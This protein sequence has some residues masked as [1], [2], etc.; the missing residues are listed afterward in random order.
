MNEALISVI[1]PV[2]NTPLKWVD[3]CVTSIIRQDYKNMEILIVDDGNKDIYSSKLKE[4]LPLDDRIRLIYRENG[5]VSSARNTGLDEAKGQYITFVD[6]D[7]Q[8]EAGAIKS[9]IELLI[10]YNA[11]IAVG[12][13]VKFSPY[14]FT[15]SQA[16]KNDLVYLYE[17]EQV[18]GLISFLLS[19]ESKDYRV[20]KMT[21]FGGV[22]CR[23]YTRAVIDRVRFD[24][25]L[26]FAEDS[27]FNIRIFSRATSVIVSSQIWYRYRMTDISATGRYRPDYYE[28]HH[29][30]LE[31]FDTYRCNLHGLAD[32]DYCMR[33]MKTYAFMVYNYIFSTKNPDSLVKKLKTVRRMVRDPIVGNLADFN[34]TEDYSKKYQLFF[35]CLKHKLSLLLFVILY[36]G[37][38]KQRI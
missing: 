18:K 15:Y 26:K 21:H 10:R 2:Y 28:E 27:L 36:I 16:Q 32:S 23:M 38:T 31:R 25:E 8:L 22:H 6:A 20:K 3:D 33:V 17:G 5:G 37:K 7:D 30:A 19:T 35:F 24:T 1:V 13:L 9:A 4:S 12:S 34:Q 29:K 14:S 11:D